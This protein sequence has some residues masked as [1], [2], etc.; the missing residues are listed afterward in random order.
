MQQRPLL[1]VLKNMVSRI[2]PS[3]IPAASPEPYATM[4][5]VALT[6]SQTS[7]VFEAEL[8]EFDQ[9]DMAGE[10][11]CRRG[12]QPSISIEDYTERLLKYMNPI[13]EEMVAALALADRVAVAGSIAITWRTVHRLYAVALVLTLKFL[14]DTYY[15]NTYY[16]RVA[17]LHTA[18]FNHLELEMLRLV[19]FH[20][21]IG[22]KEADEYR[23]SVAAVADAIESNHHDIPL[24]DE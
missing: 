5:A 1:S 12:N 3:D 22:Q 7:F 23:A 11:R 15:S 2:G 18:E 14:K 4:R 16:A 21:W 9:D 13:P 8:S 19:D 6:L 10:F 17:G 24:L 20:I